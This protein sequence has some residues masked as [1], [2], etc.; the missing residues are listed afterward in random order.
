MCEGNFEV[1]DYICVL[2]EEGRLQVNIFNGST[3]G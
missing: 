1:K 2:M 3:L